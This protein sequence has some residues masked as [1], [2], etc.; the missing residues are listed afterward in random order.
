MVFPCKSL[1]IVIVSLFFIIRNKLLSFLRRL[2]R[3]TLRGHLLELLL[4]LQ[5]CLLIIHLIVLR[6]AVVEI[7]RLT[8]LMHLLELRRVLL[9]TLVGLIDEALNFLDIDCFIQLKVLQF[10]IICHK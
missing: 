1:K 6:W 5:T 3:S 8:S 10:V 7:N 2:L 4:I 9:I